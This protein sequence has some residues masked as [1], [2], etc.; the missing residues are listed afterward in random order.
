MANVPI[1]VT[2]DANDKV[3]CNPDRARAGLGDNTIVWQCPTPG[4]TLESITIEP[5]AGQP[6][7]PGSAPSKQSDGTITASDPVASS[8]GRQIYKYSVSVSR[9]G[10]TFSVDPEVDNDPTP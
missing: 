6:A 7:W 1:T 8:P 3:R 4:V 10:Q 2:L 5:S 9:N